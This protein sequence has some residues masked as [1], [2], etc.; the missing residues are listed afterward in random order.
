MSI[1]LEG[2]LSFI[3]DNTGAEVAISKGSARAQDH[4]QLVHQQWLF[5]VSERLRI[6][7]KR[8]STADNIADLP[9]RHDVKLLEFIKAR[10]VAPV[11]EDEFLDHTA[12]EVLNERWAM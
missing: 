1:C 7:V 6:H 8:V 5:A 9:S 12:W 3:C 4:A 2:K 11:F 10:E